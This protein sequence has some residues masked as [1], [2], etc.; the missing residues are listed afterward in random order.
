MSDIAGFVTDAFQILKDTGMDK[1]TTRQAM[2]DLLVSMEDNLI[3]E[4]ERDIDEC[5]GQDDLLDSALYEYIDSLEN[6]DDF[7]YEDEE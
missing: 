1:N 3:I 5:F 2:F 7:D 6:P 4:G